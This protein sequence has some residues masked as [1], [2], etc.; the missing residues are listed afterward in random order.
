MY[1]IISVATELLNP[2]FLKKLSTPTLSC[3]SSLSQTPT[4][5]LSKDV[6][7]QTEGAQPLS[8]IFYAKYILL[9]IQ[10]HI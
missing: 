6:N 7:K 8:S 4:M 10:K 3:N 5:A 2:F 1:S 9:S